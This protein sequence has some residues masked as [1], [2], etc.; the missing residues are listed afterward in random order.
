MSAR[1]INRPISDSSSNFEVL[2]GG[3]EPFCCSGGGCNCYKA[4]LNSGRCCK[5]RA[6]QFNIA[7]KAT[8]QTQT[9]GTDLHLIP[10]ASPIGFPPASGM[11]LR[12]PRG[13]LVA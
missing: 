2:G 4:W 12:S 8:I 1:G 5:S 13:G 11:V 3:R 6:E 7:I 10:A 9:L